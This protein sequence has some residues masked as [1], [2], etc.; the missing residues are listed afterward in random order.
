MKQL[1]TVHKTC[2]NCSRYKQDIATF[3]IVPWYSKRK[4]YLMLERVAKIFKTSI[5]GI[6]LFILRIILCWQFFFDLAANFQ[7]NLPFQFFS[8]SFFPHWKWESPKPRKS[9][10]TSMAKKSPLLCEKGV[11]QQFQ[12]IAVKKLGK[13]Y[14]MHEYFLLVSCYTISEKM[15]L[16][17]KRFSALFHPSTYLPSILYEALLR[18]LPFL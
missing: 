5:I 16:L 8:S 2:S 1:S 13:K 15:L 12:A 14:S 6:F 9:I 11:C 4:G 17:V 18:R 10:Q 3:T 7:S